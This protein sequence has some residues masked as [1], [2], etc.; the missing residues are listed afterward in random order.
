MV[1]GV[2]D[3]DGRDVDDAA[4]ACDDWSDHDG[5]VD[6]D[7]ARL[8]TTAN[9]DAAEA[10]MSK[11]ENK[12]N[13]GPT[14]GEVGETEKKD[15]VGLTEGEMVETEK[16]NNVGP[17]DGDVGE[18]EKKDASSSSNGMEALLNLVGLGVG[19]VSDD[20]GDDGDDNADD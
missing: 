4:D 8:P 7:D 11:T 3:A 9:H 5:D 6:D 10:P 1:E 18:I 2:S 19:C 12:D 15:N 13:I 16:N 20:G 14:E 17:A